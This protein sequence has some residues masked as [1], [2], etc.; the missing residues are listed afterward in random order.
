MAVPFSLCSMEA[1]IKRAEQ[2]QSEYVS[3]RRK[4]HM[5]PE[6]ALEEF[7]TSAL[8]L[9]ELKRYGITILDTTCSSGVVGMLWGNPK[10]KTLALRADIDALDVQEKSGLVFSSKIDGKAHACGHDVH[11]AALLFCARLLSERKHEL[12]GN[13]KFIFQPAE[14]QMIGA[15]ELIGAGVLSKPVVS[16]IVAEHVW[17]E[18]PAGTIGIIKGAT[19]A[20]SDTFKILIRVKGGHAAHPDKTSDPIV[21]GSAIVMQLQT[22]V[23]RMI[24][25]TDSA[26]VTV[27]RFHAGDVVN[28]IPQ[29]ACLEGTV[30]CFSDETREMMEKQIRA[31]VDGFSAIYGAQVSVN[32]I[33]GIDPVISDPKIVDMIKEVGIRLLGKD[34]VIELDAPSMGSEDFAYYL[35]GIPGAVFRLGT[36]NDTDESHLSLHCNEIHFDE[37]AI[38]TGAITMCG[39]AYLYTES[40]FDGLI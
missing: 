4:I 23:S 8:I 1:L 19:M 12:R 21:I 33:R 13:I 32:Y 14:E 22:I 29:E 25:P 2:L 31:M 18:L 9:D 20:S 11:I 3:L 38:I 28:V 39:L 5:H 10:G 36:N 40:G 26:V 24:S 30:R 15:K 16:A 17:P 37:R 35:K 7:E 34:K 27:S 6:T